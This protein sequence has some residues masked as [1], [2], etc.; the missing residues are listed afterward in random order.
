LEAQLTQRDG[1]L[2]S[3]RRAHVTSAAQI[4]RL[5]LEVERAT[6]KHTMCDTLRTQLTTKLSKCL[7]FHGRTGD[8]EAEVKERLLEVE[9]AHSGCEPIQQT[10][11]AEVR[12]LTLSLATVRVELA[13][14]EA[15]STGLHATTAVALYMHNIQNVQRMCAG[16]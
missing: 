6:A 5:H 14:A 2:T 12:M 7:D 10:L 1:E 9:V 8:G 4:E 11:D 13:Q 15:R 16:G 3:L